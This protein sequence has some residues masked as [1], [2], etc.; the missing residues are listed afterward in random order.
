MAKAAQA[1]KTY[2]LKRTCMLINLERVDKSTNKSVLTRVSLKPGDEVE[3]TKQEF[4][5]FNT[6]SVFTEG[7]KNT[8]NSSFDWSEL[9]RVEEEN[10]EGLLFGKGKRQL[11]KALAYEAENQA[12]DKVIPVIAKALTDSGG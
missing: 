5:Q 3:L 6:N 4:Q 11:A 9:D 12:R 8:P 10:L 1:L 2:T 7:G